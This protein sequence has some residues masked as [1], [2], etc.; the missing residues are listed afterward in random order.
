MGR[1]WIPDWLKPR[2][3]RA[4]ETSKRTSLLHVEQRE[5]LRAPL[6]ADHGLPPAPA[7]VAHRGEIRRPRTAQPPGARSFLDCE[8]EPLPARPQL[9]RCVS[10]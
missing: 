1:S 10:I 3:K 4:A 7:A 5:A 6:R 2:K 9:N 8:D